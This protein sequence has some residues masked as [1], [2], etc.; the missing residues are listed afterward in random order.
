MKKFLHFL[1]CAAALSS[2]ATASA[3]AIGSFILDVDDAS[4]VTLKTGY[5]ANLTEIP[6]VTGENTVPY[7]KWDDYIL[8]P[9][10]GYLIESITAYDA[11]GVQQSSTGWSFDSATDSYSTY[12]TSADEDGY[13][14]VV[15]TKEYHPVMSTVTVNINNPE[16]ISGGKFKVGNVT[17]TAETSNTV[18]FNAD[19]GSTLTMSL[20]RSV[21]ETSLTLDDNEVEPESTDPYSYSFDVADGNVVNLTVT[22]ENPQI[23]LTI[24]DPSHVIVTFPDSET[25]LTDLISGSNT[26]TYAIG[27][28]LSIKAADGY[29]V[30]PVDGML[31][32]SY[33]D[34]YS[35]SFKGGES[36]TDFAVTTEVYVAPIATVILD[37]DDPSLIDYVYTSSYIRD[38]V[39]GENK[40]ELNTDKITKVEVYYDVEST[41]DVIATLDGAPL[42]VEEWW[43][44]IYSQVQLLEP[45]EYRIVA[46]RRVSGDYTGEATLTDVAE[47]KVWTLTFAPGGIVENFADNGDIT[48]S[49]AEGIVAVADVECGLDKA[50]LTF[51][52]EGELEEGDYTVTVPA[53]AFAVNGAVVGTVTSGFSIVEKTGITA[54]VAVGESLLTVYSID[55]RLILKDAPEQD[56]KALESGLYIVNGKKVA[57]TK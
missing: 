37:V 32:Y 42:A 10:D 26:L 4:H 21:S 5:G 6:L 48:L 15:V 9:A 49:D 2:V 11:N 57:L 54:P 43:Y 27:D 17:V 45:R 19:K 16:A 31:Y 40:F 1:F 3:D 29:K 33:S 14:Y 55:G 36:G 13:K 20:T 18:V 24:D 41:D 7:E 53:G 39:E 52:I 50:T 12:F 35:Y 38:I 30:N 47:H 51:G 25:V 34:T 22:M 46:R 56:F 8:T 44:E 28:E 23:T